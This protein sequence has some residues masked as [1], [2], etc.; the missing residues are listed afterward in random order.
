[1][2]K[3]PEISALRSPVGRGQ[4]SPKAIPERSEGRRRAS[5]LEVVGHH[6]VLQT[7]LGKVDDGLLDAVGSLAGLDDRALVLPERVVDQVAL[8]VGRARVVGLGLARRRLGLALGL[9]TKALAL[10][11][12][13]LPVQLLTP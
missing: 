3:A 7:H 4:R 6:E 11:G 8:L 2:V 1:M 12:L 10:G 13:L 9:G 5:D